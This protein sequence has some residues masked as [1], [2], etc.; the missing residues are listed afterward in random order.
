MTSREL[1]NTI[2]DTKEIPVDDR[3]KVDI[4]RYGMMLLHFKRCATEENFAKAYRDLRRAYKG[5]KISEEDFN[6]ITHKFCICLCN[7]GSIFTLKGELGK[8]I[9]ELK[10]ESQD[11]FNEI[12]SM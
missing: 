3:D 7:F 9:E 1:V 6:M 11:K 10:K 2:L 12:I 8:E 5:K 4:I